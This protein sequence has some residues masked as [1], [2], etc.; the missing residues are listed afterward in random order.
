[1][2]TLEVS[3]GFIAFLPIY[4]SCSTLLC[5]LY[6][7]P[8]TYLSLSFCLYLVLKNVF[9]YRPAQH[10]HDQVQGSTV[11]YNNGAQIPLNN[12]APKQQPQNHHL[13]QQLQDTGSSNGAPQVVARIMPKNQ[14][15]QQHDAGY[16]PHAHP[17][18]QQQAQYHQQTVAGNKQ[19]L[20]H[21]PHP[22]SHHH[23]QTTPT[24]QL[25]SLNQ[26]GPNP[27]HHQHQHPMEQAPTSARNNSS[28]V[29]IVELAPSQTR[30]TL[31]LSD[32]P[33]LG[34]FRL[35]HDA[36]FTSKVFHI[37]P[38]LFE[39]LSKSMNLINPQTASV[40]QELQ[41][42]A[43][44]IKP[45]AQQQTNCLN[46]GDSLLLAAANVQ[47]RACNWPELFQVSINQN[48]LNLDRS[49]PP[50]KLSPQQQQQHKA[51]DV[52]Q[53][54]RLG[55]NVI[56]IQ[57]NDC[58]CS[59]E[60]VLEAVDR[61]TIKAFMNSCFK[62]R[63]LSI[64]SCI[65]KL[66]FNFNTP[67]FLIQ[68][69]NNQQLQNA[70]IFN[71]YV[72]E[73]NQGIEIT[74]TR[75][76]LRCPIS[77]QRMRTPTRGHNCKHLQCFDL[78]KFL[79]VN[80][81][82]SQWYC[83]ICSLSIPFNMLELDQHQMNIVQAMSDTLNTDDILMDSNGQWQA[84]YVGVGQQQVQK[85]PIPVAN[86]LP[87]NQQQQQ[88][89]AAL[90]NNTAKSTGTY[91]PQAPIMNGTSPQGSQH[92]QQPLYMQQPQPMRPMSGSA[93]SNRNTQPQQVG[94][95][96]S[97]DGSNHV[98]I[99]LINQQQQQQPQM[100][101][102]SISTVS[103]PQPIAGRRSAN[104]SPLA[105]KPYA[106]QYAQQRVEQQHVVVQ[107]QQ[108]NSQYIGDHSN[109]ST[110]AASTQFNSQQLDNSDDLS[111]LAAMER[112]IIQHEQQMGPPPFDPNSLT[113]SPAPMR[114]AAT[115]GGSALISSQSP[116]HST[117]AAAT[118]QQSVSNQQQQMASA[119]TPMGT[120]QPPLVQA[121]PEARP[122]LN[123][124]RAFSPAANVVSSP[125]ARMTPAAI[126]SPQQARIQQT[127]L[128]QSP[129]QQLQQQAGGASISTPA[130]PSSSSI[131]IHGGPET[132]ATPSQLSAQQQQ[133]QHCGPNS[134]SGVTSF[135]PHIS[136][137]T[138]S[139]GG[140][141]S[142]TTNQQQITGVDHQPLSNGSASAGSITSTSTMT[143]SG[144]S[145]GSVGM[146]G[147]SRCGTAPLQGNGPLG[148]D[149]LMLPG[150]NG[151]SV[152]G[153]GVVS[154]AAGTSSTSSN[155]VAGGGSSS[156]YTTSNS[157]SKHSMLHNNHSSSHH[158]LDE[159]NHDI[160]MG[161]LMMDSSESLL[162]DHR[163]SELAIALEEAEW[164]QQLDRGKSEHLANFLNE[165][166]MNSKHANN[167]IA[168]TTNN[169]CSN[170]QQQQQQPL[171]IQQQMV[172]IQDS[173]KLISGGLNPSDD[174]ANHSHN[175]SP[176]HNL[177]Q[178]EFANYL[179]SDTVDNGAGLPP[180]DSI[181]DLFER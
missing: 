42:R 140:A 128:P 145:L 17:Q 179:D 150:C 91:H 121:S 27:M 100:A 19:H 41:F 85:Q 70:A 110:P 103:Q 47:G 3:L 117:A 177:D 105:K 16:H 165:P 113:S 23:N 98:E 64:D 38:Q 12:G 89:V 162:R 154:G 40:V 127:D 79:F 175:S 123:N 152:G 55:N 143:P 90:Q 111:P 75:I 104:G 124:G 65:Q 161:K 146:G 73:F 51:I 71:E 82:R 15:Q 97:W 160:L 58:Y 7:R 56:D 8:L 130:T 170:N 9:K 61:P 49:S 13:H 28:L 69:N 116:S 108:S 44:L 137:N 60:F 173:N 34:P 62:S 115:A 107:Q 76:S 87:S 134:V 78:E 50:T 181:L 93:L 122:Q 180:D 136:S 101:R 155:S 156:Q 26:Q 66:K 80:R 112:T 153:G 114:T 158:H 119:G 88:P 63:L 169:Y 176:S 138:S 20:N 10:Q 120:I 102:G 99:S 74:K 57:V 54:C 24:S 172:Q 18:L 171:Q 39:A 139:G 14:Q 142:G 43:Y 151:G 67:G 59:H 1:M 5:L 96:A 159:K 178:L 31:P 148:L 129:I 166:L 35:D 48:I 167:R 46:G 21:H 92:H 4:L 2:A 11:V 52:F 94:S 22:P 86:S 77:C 72:I 126:S 131:L 37:K 25:P 109:N 83:P 36:Q 125:A 29:G 106:G 30:L 157:N 33:V 6:S 147:D 118:S 32:S 132:P 149:D 163:N 84:Y 164:K 144:Q 68:N 95:P 81:E 133:Q 53:F 141:I 45:P 168:T 174:E 135:S